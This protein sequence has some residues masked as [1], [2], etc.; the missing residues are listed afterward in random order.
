M[1]KS[2]EQDALHIYD[3]VTDDMI[4]TFRFTQLVSIGSVSW[5][6][7]GKRVAFS[8]IDRGGQNDL[9]ILNTDTRELRRLTD[10]AFGL[11]TGQTYL[12]TDR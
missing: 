9:Y 10:D 11:V 3:V 4:N 12:A 1:T 5:A 6:P 8:A 2:G 7:D